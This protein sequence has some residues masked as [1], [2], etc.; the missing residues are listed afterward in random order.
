M[1]L[2]VKLVLAGDYGDEEILARLSNLLYPRVP[3]MMVTGT[4]NGKILGGR[5]RFLTSQIV[6]GRDGYSMRMP[7]L[8]G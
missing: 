5:K 4:W 6:K 2:F 1:F 3:G 7:F 8:E